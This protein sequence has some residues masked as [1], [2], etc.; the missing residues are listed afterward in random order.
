MTSILFIQPY[1]GP[2]MSLVV[3]LGIGYLGKY[4]KDRHVDVDIL[5][6]N[7]FPNPWDILKKKR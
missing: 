7:L 4:L 1:L 6:L 3:P 5:D 2:E